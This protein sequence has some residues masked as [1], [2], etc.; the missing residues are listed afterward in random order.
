MN[1]PIR[2]LHVIGIMNQ[3][4][5]ETMIMN[6]YRHIDREK[7]QF[8]FVE[9][10]NNGAFFDA[11]IQNLGGNIFHCPRF[12]GRNYLK[13]RKWWKSFFDSHNNYSI[14]HGHIGSS[15]AI[16]LKEAKNHGLVT[17]A[18]SHSIYVKDQSHFFYSLFSYPTRYIADYLF[19]CS[20]RAGADRYGK[21]AVSD[22]GRAFLVPNAIN[23]ES[24]CFH[25]STRKR[26]RQELG[27][28]DNEYV[29]GHVGRFTEAKNHSFLLDIFKEAVAE[30][31]PLKLLLV[32]DGELR[33]PI[34]NKVI[35]LGLKDKVILTGNRSDIDELLSVMDVMV[36]PSRYEGLPVTL[37]EAQCN[38]L[39]CI[40]SDRVPSDC[41]LIPE[42]ITVCSLQ[43][44]ALEWAKKALKTDRRNRSVYA[45][46]IEESS[47]NIKKS[48]RWLEEF[49]LEKS[50]Q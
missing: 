28:G 34:E 13:Y 42:L 30:S 44:N 9:N 46:R 39:P 47:F 5:A 20:E 38:G 4:G 24:F 48:A 32:G 12:T 11:E 1:N 25:E 29:I 50:K 45:N 14:V 6:L 7:V 22:P 15:A 49:Y 19:M 41:I 27:I 17:I 35:S 31:A 26:K 10:E 33:Q 36:F 21:K 23:T 40:I 8:D 3:A 37:V 16:Y 2:V 43:E 18:H